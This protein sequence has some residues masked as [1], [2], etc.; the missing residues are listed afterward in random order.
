[1]FKMTFNIIGF[2][3]YKGLKSKLPPIRYVGLDENNNELVILTHPK[4]FNRHLNLLKTAYKKT[5]TLD[6]DN[7][8]KLDKIKEDIFEIYPSIDDLTLNP[9]GFIGLFVNEKG[10]EILQNDFKE[11]DEVSKLEFIKVDNNGIN[12]GDYKLCGVIDT[13][14]KKFNSKYSLINKYKDLYLV[15]GEMKNLNIISGITYPTDKYNII[16]GKRTL[17]ENSIESTIREC[18]EEFG[19]DKENS[20]IYKLINQLVPKTKDIIRCSTFNVYCIYIK[21]KN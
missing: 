15:I 21:P 5:L 12:I 10:I 11:N 8:L 14:I 2:N 4:D 17:Y 3:H 13:F 18:T 16:G 20:S 1:M 19:L 7:E 6:L 9:N